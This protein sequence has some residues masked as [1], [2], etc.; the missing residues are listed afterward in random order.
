MASP[1]ARDFGVASGRRQA[2]VPLRGYFLMELNMQSACGRW[3]GLAVIIGLAVILP[4]PVCAAENSPSGQYAELPGV[5]LWFTD[6]GGTG[7]P[8][9]LLHATQPVPR[10]P[11]APMTFSMMTGCPGDQHDERRGYLGGRPAFR[12]VPHRRA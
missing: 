4:A 3:W 2:V 10:V 11:P 12:G 1:A 8:I 7:I 6:T 9:V 5:K